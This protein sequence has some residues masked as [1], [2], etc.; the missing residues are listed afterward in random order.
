VLDS[1]KIGAI[2]MS[3]VI[4]EFANELFSMPLT[5]SEKEKAIMIA[6]AAWNISFS[7][8]I[9]HENE[10]NKFIH[11]MNVK[12][13]SDDENEI[14]SLKFYFRNAWGWSRDF[15]LSAAKLLLFQKSLRIHTG[16]RGAGCVLDF[17]LGRMDF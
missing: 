16:R 9:Q 1:E 2:K 8:I 3:E 7:E 12:R 5:K 4:I 10:I 11:I 15:A 13:N 14:K 6:I 17:V